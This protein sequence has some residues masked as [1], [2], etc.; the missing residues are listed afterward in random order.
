MSALKRILMAH[1]RRLW[2]RYLLAMSLVM[3]ALASS[4]GMQSTALKDS[5]FDAEVINI[6]GRQRMLSQ[7]IMLLAERL[8]AGRTEQDLEKLTSA[9]ALFAQGHAWIIEN[10]LRSDRARRHYH[11]GSDTGL[12]AR[13]RAFITLAEALEAELRRG[14]DPAVRLTD[15]R[16]VDTDAL[17]WSLNEAVT[18][19]Q[20]DAVARAD[21]LVR[22]E[23]LALLMA[24]ALIVVEGLAIFWP[25]QYSVNDALDRLETANAAMQRK[26]EE[27]GAMAERVAH[28]ALHDPL[29]GLSNRKKLADALLSRMLSLGPA[30]SRLCVM[31]IDLDRFKEI[32]ATLGAS[33]GDVVLCNVAKIL[34]GVVR[35][36]DLVTRAGGDEF[37]ILMRFGAVNAVRNAIAMAESV[38]DKIRQPVVIDDRSVSVGASIGIAFSDRDTTDPRRLL[39]NAGIAL[40]EAKRAGSNMVRSFDGTMRNIVERQHHL[41]NEIVR[42]IETEAFTPVFQPLLEFATGRIAGLEALARWQHHSDGVIAPDDFIGL[43]ESTGLIK[44]IDWQI[45]RKA[46]DR[47]AEISRRDGWLPRLT[48]NASA[49]S[50]REP[51]YASR[52]V[53]AIADRGL[54]PAAVSVEVTE[55]TLIEGESDRAV[56]TIAHL[57]GHG[58]GI[59]IDDFG[60]GYSSMSQ[61]AALPF[62]G[63]K[64]DRSLVSGIEEPRQAKILAAIVGLA[65]GMELKVV[66][67]GVSSPAQFQRL[68]ALGCDFAQGYGISKPLTEDQ[69]LDWLDRYSGAAHEIAC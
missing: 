5:S 59:L 1:P 34:S 63:L 18:I 51:D 32:N 33:A 39:G 13:S 58:L 53:A 54:P 46:L 26:N 48:V 56:E 16:A 38:I 3:A 52:L 9:L 64:I 45:T 24:V 60:T 4:Y 62:T 15:L 35:N 12:D 67:E 41:R 21:R 42:A 36:D 29:T 10:G 23:D 25:A 47:L 27:L 14:A 20:A 2:I 17:L 8:G 44:E 30:Q 50:L 61:L 28:S 40:H 49:H 65:R 37:I 7:R 68:R 19:F 57:A 31:H 69:L 43:A 55:T 22:L 11:G 6:G 66:A